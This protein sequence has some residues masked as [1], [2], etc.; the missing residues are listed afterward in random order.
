MKAPAQPAATEEP[1][2]QAEVKTETDDNIK[3]EPTGSTAD[4]VG[5]VTKQEAENEGAITAPP[6]VM[7]KKRKAK[8]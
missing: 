4:I 7:F 3:T 2:S 8:R 6:P 1:A 5:E